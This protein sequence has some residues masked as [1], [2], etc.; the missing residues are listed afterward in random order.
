VTGRIIS[1]TLPAVPAGV[2]G[3]TLEFS[4]DGQGW[5]AF[6]PTSLTPADFEDPDALL[7]LPEG[8]YLIDGINDPV[9]TPRRL[10]PTGTA[11]GSDGCRLPATATP[12][13]SS[14]CLTGSCR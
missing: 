6:S 10:P 11:T 8:A 3:F 5:T 14:G 9:G 13:K 12:A 1:I 2:T 4:V 7:A